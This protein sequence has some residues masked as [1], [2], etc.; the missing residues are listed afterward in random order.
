MI[1][2][3]KLL[4]EIYYHVHHI[5]WTPKYRYN[6]LE[7]PLKEFLIFRITDTNGV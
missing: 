6:V 1:N 2:Y 5:V 7:G 3:I 4:Y